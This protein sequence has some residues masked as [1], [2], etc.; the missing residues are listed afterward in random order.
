VLNAVYVL[1]ANVGA[2]NGGMT[3]VD[4]L[5]TAHG[6]VKLR[7][8]SLGNLRIGEGVFSHMYVSLPS[9]YCHTVP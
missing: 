2:Y 6:G 8:L 3:V 5:L 4:L 1:R 7:S 9:R